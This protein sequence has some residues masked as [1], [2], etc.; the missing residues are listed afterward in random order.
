MIGRTR[1]LCRVGNV[2][3]PTH[4]PTH[5]H[6][7]ANRTQENCSKSHRKHFV[8]KKLQ[9]VLPNICRNSL[10]FAHALAPARKWRF[11]RPNQIK[12]GKAIFYLVAHPPP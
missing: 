12:N 6:H 11:A 9:N 7:L 3:F 1:S 4:I 8:Q 2:V 5:K 10:V